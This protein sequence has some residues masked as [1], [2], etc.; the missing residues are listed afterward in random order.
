MNSN[1]LEFDKNNIKNYTSKDKDYYRIYM[2]ERYQNNTCKKVDCDVCGK[3]VIYASIARHKKSDK[4]KKSSE[5]YQLSVN[6][7][8]A[9]LEKMLSRFSS[10]YLDMDIVNEQFIK[11]N[12][13]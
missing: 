6:E 13:E 5:S 3:S 2:K 1:T 4:C 12:L 8:L 10:E 9:R 7:R 11:D